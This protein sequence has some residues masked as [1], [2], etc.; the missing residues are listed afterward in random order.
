MLPLPLNLMR[1]TSARFKVVAVMLLLWPAIIWEQGATPSRVGMQLSQKAN[2]VF[3]QRD[4][5]L[6]THLQA[7]RGETPIGVI[8]VELRPLS[9]GAAYQDQNLMCFTSLATPYLRVMRGVGR[10]MG[11]KLLFTI[12]HLFF[13]NL[14]EYMAERVGDERIEPPASLARPQT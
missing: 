11:V 14:A 7:F 5:V 10:I 2:G 12:I 4:D 6:F 8:Q 3:R 13:S 1:S 9:L